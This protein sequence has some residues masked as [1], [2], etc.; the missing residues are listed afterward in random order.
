M[1]NHPDETLAIEQKH[2]PNLS[3]TVLQQSLQFIPFA[4]DGMQSQKGWDSAVALAQQ[5]G[6]IQGVTGA[7]EGVYWT[8]KYIGSSRLGQ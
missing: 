5:T 8:N 3:K 7:S 1:R 2:F 4:R 6:L